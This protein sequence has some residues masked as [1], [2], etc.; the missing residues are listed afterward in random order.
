[1]AAKKKAGG[2]RGP[3]EV[4]SPQEDKFCQHYAT[5]GNGSDAIRHAYPEWRGKDIQHIAVKASKLLAMSKM[6]VRIIKYQAQLAN[7]AEKKFEITAEKVLQELAAIAFQNSEDYFEWGAFDRQVWKKNKETGRSEPVVDDKGQPVVESVQYVRAK[8]SAELTRTQKA[9]VLS[10]SE[11]VTKT[12]DRV[13]EL[14]MGDKLG[15]LKAL[16]QHLGLFK[17]RVAVE[18][19]GKNGG[20]IEHKQ[21]SAEEMARTDP[22]EALRMFESFR[23]QQQ[24]SGP[25]TH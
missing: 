3:R 5:Y 4:V 10:A 16:G 8:P 21:V 9:A 22:R 14:K 6:K 7:I 2:K 25:T 19:T 17:E 20:P 15:A 11:T 13:M 23:V 1:M 12:G 24:S 18:H